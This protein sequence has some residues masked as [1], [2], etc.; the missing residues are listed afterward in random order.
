MKEHADE[1][2]QS[3]ISK[4][5]NTDQ[6]VGYL[7]NERFINIPAK[8]SVPL[9]SSLHDEIERIKKKEKS[10]CFDYYI[11]ICKTS[12]PKDNSGNRY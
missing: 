11:M 7:I 2:T 3:S 8:I 6:K 4:I 12:R 10:Y 9:L 5:L 1:N